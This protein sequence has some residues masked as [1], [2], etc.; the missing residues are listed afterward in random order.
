MTTLPTQGWEL[1]FFHQDHSSRSYVIEFK[2]GYSASFDFLHDTATLSYSGQ[3]VQ[4][5][6]Q[7][8]ILKSVGNNSIAAAARYDALQQ[9]V[10]TPNSDMAMGWVL[11]TGSLSGGLFGAP[12]PGASPRLTAPNAPGPMNCWPVQAPCDGWSTSLGDWGTYH[13]WWDGPWNQPGPVNCAPDDIDCALY[14]HD[15]QA[16][17]GHF[18]SNLGI[19]ISTTIGAMAACAGTPLTGGGLVLVC[20]GATL[21]DLMAVQQMSNDMDLCHSPYS[22]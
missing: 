4:L 8:V 11:G 16:A 7:S 5:P 10:A 15:R 2:N 12:S 17:C 18:G 6:L 20:G 14:E 22:G 19:V 21:G 1:A 13:A 9:S 3:K